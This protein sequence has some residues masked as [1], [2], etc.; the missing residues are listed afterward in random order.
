MA[1]KM[2]KFLYHGLVLSFFCSSGSS[3][4]RWPILRKSTVVAISSWKCL[5]LMLKIKILFWGKLLHFIAL[6]RSHNK[7]SLVATTG[8]L[9]TLYASLLVDCHWFKSSEITLF[10]PRTSPSPSPLGGPCAIPLSTRYIPISDD[11]IV[12][13]PHKENVKNIFFALD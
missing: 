5:V 11:V 2:V 4:L 10:L 12:G 1:V 7:A 8:V 13:R 3:V 6:E 9:Y